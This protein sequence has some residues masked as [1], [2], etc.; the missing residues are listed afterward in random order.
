MAKPCG[1]SSRHEA[2]LSSFAQI[3]WSFEKRQPRNES[4][5]EQVKHSID[6]SESSLHVFEG[7]RV[8]FFGS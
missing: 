2:F 5:K 8:V 7:C 4:N 1:K 6:R 3:S